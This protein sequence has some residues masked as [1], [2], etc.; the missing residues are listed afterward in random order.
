MI[1][2]E[3]L[4]DGKLIRYYSDAGVMLR[5]IETNA[6]YAEAVDIVPSPYTYEETEDIIKRTVLLSYNQVAEV[7]NK[8]AMA[9]ALLGYSKDEAWEFI[10]S[11]P[12]C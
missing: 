2:T 4:Q 7:L 12:S 8:N 3:Y 1:R 5:Q 9:L 6:L 11:L 10:R